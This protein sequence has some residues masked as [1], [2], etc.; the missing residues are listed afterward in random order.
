MTYLIGAMLSTGVGLQDVH[1]DDIEF[2]MVQPP[3]NSTCEEYIGPFVE[4][5]GGSL[6]NPEANESCL[7]CPISSTDTFLDTVD[8]YYD[9]RWR[10]FGLV[11]V[12]VFF[13][14][15]AAL[16]AFWLFRV[17]KKGIFGLGKGI[18]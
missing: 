9:Q 13:N 7:Y 1:C 2:L 17:P 4:M 16:G 11:W 14:I 3:A 15:F 6:Q 5:V 18:L 8:I 10:N 12:Y